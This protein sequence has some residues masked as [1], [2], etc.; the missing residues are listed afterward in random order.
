MAERGTRETS[1]TFV[2]I[3]LLFALPF[4]RVVA[5]YA[6]AFFTGVI[7]AVLSHPVYA[8]LVRRRIRP[9]FSSGIVTAGLVVGVMGPLAWFLWSALNQAI[10]LVTRLSGE[11]LDV[12]ALVD[13]L[14]GWRLLQRFV[15]D[16]VALKVQLDE[17][18]THLAR[19]AGN[20]AFVVATRIPDYVIQGVMCTL[21]VYFMLID[22]R[23]LYDWVT[24]K[25]PL[26]LEVRESLAAS[27]RSAARAVVLSSMAATGAQALI[28]LVGFLSLGVPLA[29][30]AAFTGFVLAW[31]P[32]AGI[33][34]VWGAGM[35]W[36]YQEGDLTRMFLMLGVGVVVGVVD[37]IVRPLVLGGREGMHP[38]VSL[39][40]IFG[41]IASFG[42]VGVFIGPVLAAMVKAVLDT[43][44]AVAR[45]CNVPIADN[46]QLP[47][48]DVPHAPASPQDSVRP[49]Q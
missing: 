45:E 31:V 46:G 39:L 33:T 27:F 32:M 24:G 16:P 22:G 44:P 12:D 4:L 41:G 37:N 7:L 14:L 26:P 10:A 28:I 13:R 19:E 34:P 6:L 47:E 17:A 11:D 23:R 21:T 8:W 43:W 1:I 15:T 3:I 18:A 35:F 36:L 49:V 30:L 42:M 9:I 20:L 25:L 2:F 40:S 29:F 48:V 5:P 38:L